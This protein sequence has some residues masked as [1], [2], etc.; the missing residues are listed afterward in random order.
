MIADAE[1]RADARNAVRLAAAREPVRARD[2]DAQWLVDLA[3]RGDVRGGAGPFRLVD[4][5]ARGTTRSDG[6]VWSEDEA[7][8]DLL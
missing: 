6:S 4:E 3:P 5:S 8:L 2:D 7:V 1:G